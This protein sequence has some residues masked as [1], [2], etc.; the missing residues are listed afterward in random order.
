MRSLR[1]DLFQSSDKIS[2]ESLALR[3]C[4]Y[5]LR[6]AHQLIDDVVDQ[7]DFPLFGGASKLHQH[8][9]FLTVPS[10]AK[11][12]VALASV[13]SNAPHLLLD[14]GNLVN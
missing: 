12:L 14:H 4:Q 8:A 13:V 11:K 1:S 6:F 5:C 2:V 3:A 7:V 10:L 9:R